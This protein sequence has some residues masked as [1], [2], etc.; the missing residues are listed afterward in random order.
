[1]RPSAPS[2]L[3][4]VERVAEEADHLGGVKRIVAG[5]DDER[6]QLGRGDRGDAGADILAAG[7]IF[8]RLGAGEAGED[9]LRLLDALG[10][11]RDDGAADPRPL[12]ITASTTRRSIGWP[13]MSMKHLCETPPACASGSRLPRLAASTSA[14]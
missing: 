13:A 4:V 1:M 7:D 9:R 2:A 12:A 6:Q 11:D 10:L 14:V 3:D 5:G 8:D